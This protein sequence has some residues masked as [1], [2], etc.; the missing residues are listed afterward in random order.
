MRLRKERVA[1][2]ARRLADRL[3]EL[4]GVEVHGDRQSIEFQFS[5]ALLDD[6]A[7]EEALEEEV[8][9]ILAIHLKG[10]SRDS[11]NYAE[12]FRKAKAQLA[13]ERGIAL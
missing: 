10:K 1:Q 2:I 8:H 9:K 4:E 3:F 12:L 6:L 13:R 7:G 11:V 5:E